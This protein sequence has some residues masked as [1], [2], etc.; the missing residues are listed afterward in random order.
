MIIA[1]IAV[2]IAGLL[3]RYVL[4]PFMERTLRRHGL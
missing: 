2:V 4:A 3:S 1:I